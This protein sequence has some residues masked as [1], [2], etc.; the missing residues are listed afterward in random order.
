MLVLHFRHLEASGDVLRHVTCERCKRGFD[1]RLE[2][3]T[4]IDT[5]P[6]PMLV[7]QAEAICQRR[8]AARLATDVEPVA[9]PSCGWMQAEMVEELRRRFAGGLR[10]CGIVF[11]IASAT[12]SIVFALMGIWFWYRPLRLDLDC[13]GIAGAGAAGCLVGLMMI[14]LRAV[15]GRWRYRAW[16]RP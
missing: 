4:A 3:S 13:W 8:L 16:G 11:A 12:L 6:L 1:Y 15:L 2:R 9:C 7:R 10:A 5:V 14:G